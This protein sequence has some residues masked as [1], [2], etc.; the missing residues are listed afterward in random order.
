MRKYTLDEVTAALR[1]GDGTE[2]GFTDADRARVLRNPHLQKKLA[3]LQAAGEALRGERVYEL[4]FS[5]FR[6]FE[7]DGD[8]V[9]F[10][11]AADGYFVRRRRLAIYGIL[12]WLYGRDEDIAALEDVL[13]AICSEYTWV[14]PAHLGGKG[15]SVLQ[16]DGTYTIDL[17]A[18]ETGEGVAEV[19]DL[20]GDR[21]APIVVERCRHELKRRL[22]DRCTDRFSWNTTGTN[23]WVCVCNGNCGITAMYAER[24]PARLAEILTS[25]INGIQNYQKSIGS[26]G[27]CSEGL[28]YWAYGVGNYLYFADMLKK[29]T[30]GII[31]LM[32]NE[33][34][35]RT[36]RFCGDCLLPDGEYVSFADMWGKK[37]FYLLPGLMS[38]L[39]RIYPEV[40][41]AGRE[42]MDFSFPD[43]LRLRFGRELREFVWV[44]EDLET[45]MSMD[46]SPKI[47]PES[48]LYIATSESGV[49]LAAKGG[50]NAEAHNHND[51]GSF[52]IVKSGRRML[53]DIGASEYTRDYFTEGRYTK[54]FAPSSQAHNLPIVNGRG[55]A[56]GA[57]HGARGTVITPDG[58]R[59][60]IAAAYDDDTL[61]SLVRDIRFDRKNGRV[62]LKDTYEFTEA[63]KSVYERFICPVEPTIGN[64][65]IIFANGSERITLFYDGDAFD[66]RIAGVT[67]MRHDCREER[68]TWTVDLVMKK[69]EKRFGIEFTIE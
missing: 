37:L 57:D 34:L 40:P 1:A 8:R 56:C 30:A 48:E 21:L 54:H 32:D 5:A 25:C 50:H 29:R 24:D 10:E 59:A 6:R 42:L 63:P 51:V 12:S 67:D 52:M 65:R 38:Q 3:D 41:L 35:R 9:E 27:A 49:S 60:D 13:W 45:R 64:G 23:N 61:I 53:D 55:Q 31:D 46:Y 19:L 20:V 7:T 47:Y 28:G 62:I 68:V 16:T 66:V 18:A 33:K 15:L 58:L 17:F 4:R 36:A 69:T 26:D 39:N 44:A 11:S 22:L 43:I 2:I 14:L